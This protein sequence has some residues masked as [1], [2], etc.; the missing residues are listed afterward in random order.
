MTILPYRGRFAPSPTGKPHIGTLI[1]AVAS[2]LQARKHNG[3]WLLRIEDV[4]TRRRVPGADDTLLRV[5]EKFGFEWDQ[6]VVWQSSRTGLYQQAL[7]QLS[8]DE[9]TFPCTCSRKL[10]AQTA[11]ELSGIYPGTCR[12]RKPP[13]Q[14]EHAIRLR[15][16]DVTIR[17]DDAVAGEYSQSLTRDCGD[18]VVKRRDG[19]FAYQ[20]AVIVDDAHQGVTEVVR[21]ADLL[22]ST[23]RQ[24]YL[25]RCLGYAEPDYL[26]LP[27]I[28]DRHGRKLSKS[29][30]SAELDPAKP[31][32]SLYT[33]LSHLGQHP[34]A[35]LAQA[36]TADIW[37]WAVENWDS[38]KIPKTPSIL[39]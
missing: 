16:A 36:G 37:Q 38:S 31:G 2:Y 39:E 17:F 6:A 21:G 9:R 3:E 7:E 10:L 15:V 24:I 13:L 14:H 11:T 27:L 20:L 32:I 34:P 18:F 1:A 12:T 33:A 30:G 19:L 5:L 25:Q 4:D 35:E 28:L 8:A 23:P 29:E 22:D 26:H